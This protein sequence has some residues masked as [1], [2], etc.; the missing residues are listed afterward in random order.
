MVALSEFQSH[1]MPTLLTL[2]FIA[3]E[4]TCAVRVSHGITLSP[5]S[6][7]ASGGLAQGRALALRGGALDMS[8]GGL[9]KAYAAALAAK[10]ILTKSVTSGAIFALSD[11]TGQTIEGAKASDLKRTLTSGLVRPLGS[12]PNSSLRVRARDPLCCL[13]CGRHADIARPDRCAHRWGSC[14]S[15]QRSTTGCQ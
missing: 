5:L 14:T 4:L 11:V 7:S 6:R 12:H 10:P 15:A 8:I 2:L 1:E 3:A 9:G 13:C